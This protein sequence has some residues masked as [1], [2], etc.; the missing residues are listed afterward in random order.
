MDT[1]S[2]LSEKELY[3]H[4]LANSPAIIGIFNYDTFCYELISKNVK[5][6]FGYEAQE[7]LEG[8]LPF[9]YS[10]MLPIH[11][12]IISGTIYP[13]YLD[14]CKRFSENEEVKNLK[15]SYEYAVESKSGKILWSLHQ[16]TII[17]V[18]EKGNPTHNLFFISDINES[19][20]DDLINFSISKKDQN[21]VYETI[22]SI[23]YPTRTVDLLS[24]RELQLLR[25]ICDG[26]STLDISALLNISVNTVKSHRK[27]IL[28]K[29]ELKNTFDLVKMAYK[30]GV[31]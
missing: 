3:T 20:K 22:F 10:K 6:I 5:N 21:G 30:T 2:S 12:A 15:F 9:N 4:L 29:M 24:N 28:Q 16:C 18:D 27:N 7:Y 31:F 19:K 13:I 1:S 23:S 25:L 17:K 14:Y 11:S 8:G 26:K